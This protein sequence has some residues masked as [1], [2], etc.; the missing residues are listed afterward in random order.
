MI[1]KLES[2]IPQM[3]DNTYVAPG[4]HVIGNV[5]LKLAAAYGLMQCYAVTW[6]K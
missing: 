6:T 5:E 3:A 4:A 2:Q 1:Y